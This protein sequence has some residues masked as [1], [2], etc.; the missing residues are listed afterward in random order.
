[1]VE[2]S[3][4]ASI[5]VLTF[6]VATMLSL[7]MQTGA[8]GLTSLM[9][10]RRF[11]VRTLA[12]NF[13]LVPIAGVALILLLPLQAPVA[14]ALLL[15]ACTPG[16]L[17]AV[18]FNSQVK[19]RAAFTVAVMCLLAV[20]AVF[21]SPLILKLLLPAE[22]RLV[23]PYGGALLFF[24]LFLL[25]PLV[26]GM[27]LLTNA[28]GVAATLAKPVA[29]AGVAAFVGFMVQTGSIRQ[30]A[31]GA[32][33]TVQAAAMVLFILVSMAIGW[34]MAGPERDSRRILATAT[35]MRNV[36]LCMAVVQA[37]AP[38]HAVLV[39]LIAF[40]L[41][42]VPTNLLFS[43]YNAAQAKRAPRANGGLRVP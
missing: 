38:G 24:M 42:M 19:G 20:L 43:L 23:I 40:S 26:A 39:P 36:A 35:S 15:L 10:S 2:L 34:F 41:L 33:G 7:G 31:V 32:I 16:G 27:L 9:T 28:P 5:L 11:L 29:L 18:Q 14:G 4:T 22:V 8:S 1:M 30:L 3:G 25:A 37:S 12:A 21:V 17:S 13:L 6:L